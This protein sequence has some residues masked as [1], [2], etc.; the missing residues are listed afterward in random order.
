MVSSPYD[1]YIIEEDGSLTERIFDEYSELNLSAAPR[2]T[3]VTTAEAALEMMTKRRFDLVLAMKRLSDMDVVE[4]GRKVKKLRPN[5]KVVLLAFDHPEIE[6]LSHYIHPDAIDMVFMWSGDT[7]ILLAIIKYME[8]IQNVDHDIEMANVRVIIMVEDSIRFYSS[9][10]GLLYAELMHQSSLLFSEGVNRMHKLLHMRSRPKILLARDFEQGVALCEKYKKN[11]MTVISDVG[12][13]RGGIRDPEAGIKLA[14]WLTG[15]ITEAPILLH[16]SEASMR[17]QAEEVGAF[18]LRKNSPRLH[19][20]IR[21]FLTHQLGFGP[22]VFRLPDYSEVGRAHDVRELERML[23]HIPSESLRHHA[24]SNHISIWLM[25]RSEYDL[26]SRLRPR[27]VSD[28]KDIEDVR[29]YLL[30]VLAKA[31][32]ARHSGVIAEYQR[33]RLEPDNRFLRIGEGSIGGKARGIAFV[34]MLLSDEKFDEKFE[35]LKVQVPQTLVLCTNW[36]DRFLEE[37][38]LDEVAY[39]SED[40]ERIINAFIKAQLPKELE[41][42]LSFI[43]E[44]FTFPLAVRSSSLLEDS[45]FQPFAG[46]YET[47]M[48]PNSDPD[49]EAR[50]RHLFRAIK[51]V[52]ASTFLQNAKAYIDNTARRIEEEKMA[53]VIQ[54]VIG[55]RYHERYYPAF[56]GVTQS[57]NYYPIGHQ[58][59]EQGITMVALGLGRM[60][61]DGGQALRFCP[62]H[63]QVLPQYS[64]PAAMLKNSQ[65]G[66]WAI[67][68]NHSFSDDF[69]HK[70]TTLK[71]YRLE[72]AEK[73][74]VLALMGGVY[75]AADDRIRDGL[76]DPG[77]RVITFNNFL[78]YKIMPLCPALIDLLQTCKAGMGSDVEI[79]FAFDMGDWG[80]TLD[81]GQPRKVPSVQVLQLRPIVS[82]M[83]LENH[84]CHDFRDDQCVSKTDMALGHGLHLDICDL[85]YVRRDNFDPKNNKKIAEEVGRINKTIKEQKRRYILIGP[86]RWGSA[87]PWLGI[88][89]QWSQISK[90]RVIVEASPK[91]YNVDPSQGTHFFQNITSLRIGY[92]T[93]PPGASKGEFSSFV[94]WD[95]L[96]ALPNHSNSEFLRHVR[97]DECFV[98]HIDGRKGQGIITKPGVPA[99]PY[100]AA[101]LDL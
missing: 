59:A 98:V 26:A 21:N 31:R 88:P 63:P 32:R 13:N 56:S 94:D 89:V 91:G 40:D 37:N 80:K 54:G 72:E 60:V 77:P 68:M 25:A 71:Y 99:D 70:Q 6:S 12:Y 33:A 53:V 67:N 35:G 52:Y 9:F 57:F 73:D 23:L 27:K 51:L 65:T 1:A 17:T 34:N 22:F 41:A 29:Q 90:A 93:V 2:V 16:S 39:H 28:F 69:E 64:T 49:F 43:L 74:G 18:F 97:V 55:Q 20:H 101:A 96:D 42:E 47:Y 44:N 48:L 92:L 11:L 84:E 15:G 82:E 14:S 5:R 95:Y 8:D 66:Y 85:V 58:K 79:E 38:S 62:Y 45:Q 76:N 75:S 46:I 83:G 30:D 100:L 50:K 36:F 61:V 81:R 3:H 4:F 10:L 19:R 78:K 87:D 86:G 24:K 7:R